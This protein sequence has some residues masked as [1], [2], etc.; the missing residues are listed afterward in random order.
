MRA[1]QAETK[2]EGVA[3]GGELD[4]GRKTHHATGRCRGGFRSTGADERDHAGIGVA[5][6]R[7]LGIGGLKLGGDVGAAGLESEGNRGGQRGLGGDG[8][9]VIVGVDEAGGLH[10]VPDGGRIGVG[11]SGVGH[12]ESAETSG[13]D[14]GRDVVEHAGG[15]A[16]TG[17]ELA[18]GAGGGR[19][20]DPEGAVVV[21]EDKERGHA[22]DDG[23]SLIAGVAI[24]HGA[25]HGTGRGSGDEQIGE[26]RGGSG[27][28]GEA[29]HKDGT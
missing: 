24:Q 2:R 17:E 1:D 9:H 29:D 14:R 10:G 6:E 18:V 19:P 12:T 15:D 20:V 25:A 22:P 16:A 5:G 11:E 21:G 7:L 27:T 8:L 23:R 26:T 3:G 13:V 28:G 4:A